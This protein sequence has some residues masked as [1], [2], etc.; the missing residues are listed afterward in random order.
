ME[1]D[2]LKF[3]NKIAKLRKL[4]GFNKFEMS[5]QSDLQYQFYCNIEAGRVKPPFK[6]VITIANALGTT[7]DE[8]IE[9]SNDK[10]P[11]RDI[12]EKDIVKKLNLINDENILKEINEVIFFMRKDKSCS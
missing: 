10:T 5:I 4:R 2:K 12:M 11:E 8:L 9:N 1:F 3:S 6:A 7:V